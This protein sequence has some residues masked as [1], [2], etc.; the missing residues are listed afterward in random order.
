[1][2]I[3]ERGTLYFNCPRP[4]LW[5]TSTQTTLFFQFAESPHDRS[6]QPNAG[7]IRTSSKYNRSTKV[8]YKA[9]TLIARVLLVSPYPTWP[10]G[11]WKPQHELILKTIKKAARRPNLGTG[12]FAYEEAMHEIVLVVTTHDRFV[13]VE[14]NVAHASRISCTR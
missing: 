12:A 8:H 13:S 6:L 5:Y 1:M 10:G 2:C 4:A 3:N 14:Y 11:I 9:C 7:P